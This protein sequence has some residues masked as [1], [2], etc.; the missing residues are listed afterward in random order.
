MNVTQSPNRYLNT[1]V[2]GKNSFRVWV[3]GNNQNGYYMNVLFVN[4]MIGFYRG[5][6]EIWDLRIAEHLRR[7]G[8]DVMFYY[9]EPVNDNAPSP[10]EEFESVPVKTPYLQNLAYAAPIGVGGILSD[11]DRNLFARKAIN[12]IRKSNYDYDIIHVCSKPKFAYLASSLDT[13]IVTTMHGTPHSLFHDYLNPLSSSYHLLESSDVIN[14]IGVASEKVENRTNSD[15]VSVNPGVDTD[16]FTPEGKIIETERPTILFVGRFVPAKD[17]DTLIDGFSEIVEKYPGSELLLIG[18]GPLMGQVQSKVEKM[19]ISENIR[20][21]GYVE[22]EDL[23]K[24]YRSSDI[25]V[26]SSRSENHPITLMEAMS[27][28]LPVIA[29]D[30]GWIPNMM[31]DGQEGRIVTQGDVGELADAIEY[32]LESE[33]RK[34]KM[35]NRGRER[36]EKEF[37]WESR[38]ESLR[39]IF[40]S[41][42]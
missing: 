26:L 10:I 2:T 1:N 40:E 16:L 38:A 9:G 15:V 4:R 6:G 21:A 17:L 32:I 42:S 19:S 8:V 14:G 33:E 28:G 35:G 20:L 3:I 22:N 11:I 34:K 39:G 25:F 7:L 12:M 13:P 5:G 30:I 27:C 41:L 37:E 24:Y 36:A 23:A 18:D 29:P 31:T